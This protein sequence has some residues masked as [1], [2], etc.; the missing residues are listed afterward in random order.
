MAERIRGN[1]SIAARITL[2]SIVQTCFDVSRTSLQKNT[3][4]AADDGPTGHADD[5]LTLTLEGIV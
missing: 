5:A 3:P 2:D 4:S 1:P